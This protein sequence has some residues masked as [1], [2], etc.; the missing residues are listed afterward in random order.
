VGGVDDQHL[1]VVADQPDVV[2]DL[3]VSPSRR[4]RAR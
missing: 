4:E 1:V 3:E 2:V